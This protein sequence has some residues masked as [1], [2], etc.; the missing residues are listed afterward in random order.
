MIYDSVIFL[1]E[2]GIEVIYDAE[3][4]FDGYKKNR[5]YA[6]GNYKRG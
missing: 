2:H 6:H 1:K 4:F 3:H 5:E